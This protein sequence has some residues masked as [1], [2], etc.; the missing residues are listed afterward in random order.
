MKIKASLS[1][2]RPQYGDGRKLI[3][4]TIVDENSR[5][6]F[7]DAEISYENF[8]QA[9][10]G[11]GHQ[12]MEIEVRGLDRVGKK[13]VCEDRIIEC[14]LKTHDRNVYRAWLD[15]NAQEEGWLLNSYLG[16]QN[17]ISYKD[18]KTILRYRVTKYVDQE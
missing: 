16:S 8:T 9:I 17:S 1:I 13:V 4:I 3:S 2:S 12:E 10:T 7:I 14:P 6:E 11:L 18:G 15:D 5:I